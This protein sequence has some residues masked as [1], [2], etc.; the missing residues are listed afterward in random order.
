MSKTAFAA[1]AILS[2]ALG[3]HPARAEAPVPP[4][5]KDFAMAAAQGDQ[6]EI[7]AARVAEVEGRDPGVRA[8]AQEMIRDHARMREALRQAAAASG[9]P[10]PPPGM[11]G[12]QARL[13]GALQSLRGADFDRAYAHQQVLAHVQA[14]AV[15]ETFAASGADPGLRKAAQSALPMIRDHLAE[16]RQLSQRL[17]GS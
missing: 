12:D 17:G 11:S 14:V 9:L 8:F 15:Q 10:P 13:L 5:P 4:S 7:E 2:A 6:Y 3:V 16:A 1:A